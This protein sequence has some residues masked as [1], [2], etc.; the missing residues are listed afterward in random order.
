VAVTRQAQTQLPIVAAVA[1]AAAMVKTA[2]TAVLVA[3]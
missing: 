1:A 3:S 2:A